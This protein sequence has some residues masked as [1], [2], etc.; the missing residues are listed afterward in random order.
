MSDHEKRVFNCELREAIAGALNDAYHE[1]R[2]GHVNYRL[3]AEDVLYARRVAV[4]MRYGLAD[5]EWKQVP[6]NATA[7][8][9]M[10]RVAKLSGPSAVLPDEVR[11]L[12][13]IRPKA[14]DTWDPPYLKPEPSDAPRDWP[15]VTGLWS[16]WIEQLIRI[17]Q[18]ANTK[19]PRE[20]GDDAE[21]AAS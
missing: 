9:M 2:A 8:D 14:P 20:P 16:V 5:W 15:E 6:E 12:L 3:T 7:L 21:E 19:P 10:R 11:R 1:Q 18:S 13:E 17:R 4:W